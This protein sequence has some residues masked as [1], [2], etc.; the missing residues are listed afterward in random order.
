[1]V[2][3]ARHD[4]LDTPSTSWFDVLGALS[5]GA[6]AAIFWK[7]PVGLAYLRLEPGRSAFPVGATDGVGISRWREH[8]V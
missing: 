3:E 2:D 1:M 6:T 5:E 4:T 8:L 7:P